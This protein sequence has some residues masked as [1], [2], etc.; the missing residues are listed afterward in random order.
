MAIDVPSTRMLRRL[1]AE[2]LSPDLVD[3]NG[4][5]PLMRAAMVKNT[6]AV[7]ALL[8]H[9]SRSLCARREGTN[10]RGHCTGCRSRGT[11][12]NSGAR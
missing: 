12:Q 6:L 11:R 10:R 3:A 7:E 9:G 2:G 5:T 4:N 8:E 1:L